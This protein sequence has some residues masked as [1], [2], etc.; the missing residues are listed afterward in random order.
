M[1]LVSEALKKARNE[2]ARREASERGLAYPTVPHHLPVQRPER[3]V[4]PW[5]V[6]SGVFVA[7]A[8]GALTA[9]Y[10]GRAPAPPSAAATSAPPSQRTVPASVA[11]HEAPPVDGVPRIEDSPPATHSPTTMQPTTTPPARTARGAAPPARAAANLPIAAAALA[12][13][14]AANSS[15]ATAP[16]S[17]PAAEPA[18]SAPAGR[19]AEPR[20]EP[21]ASSPP[22]P[23]TGSVPTSREAPLTFVRHA[24]LPD[25]V[26][27]DLGG[28][29]FSSGW[30]VALINGRALGPGEQ[31]QGYTITAIEPDV[32]LLEKTGVRIRLA[33]KD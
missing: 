28:I 11:E 26:R 3:R 9:V 8:L 16:T 30:P 31:I 5:A 21:A 25:G 13:T 15:R 14:S 19:I 10:V 23:P 2:A 1:S 24:E 18:A 27:L 17:A 7:L 6:G 20:A 32:V 22:T 4:W 33:L 29:A 12:P